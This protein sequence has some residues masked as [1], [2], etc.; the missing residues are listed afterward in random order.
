[1]RKSARASNNSVQNLCPIFDAT[2]P[3]TR[4]CFLLQ[5]DAPLDDLQTEEQPK[6]KD[7]FGKILLWNFGIMLGFMTL[8]GLSG[9][10]DSLIV[11]LLLMI[12]QVAANL[13]LGIIFVVQRKYN[14]GLAF[15]LSAFLVVIIGAG[16]CAGKAS[17]LGG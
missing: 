16:M 5:M 9:N 8:T 11:D 14:A 1:M 13:L 4:H 3:F 7:A 12:V 10:T 15:L 2:I 6:R 17:L